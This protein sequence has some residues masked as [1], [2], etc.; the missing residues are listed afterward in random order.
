MKFPALGDNLFGKIANSY[1]E[2]ASCE[3]VV[4]SA[5]QFLRNWNFLHLGKNFLTKIAN[6]DEKNRSLEEV[7]RWNLSEPKFLHPSANISRG[8]RNHRDFL[9]SRSYANI[10]RNEIL[11]N[12]FK[13]AASS[14]TFIS[15]NS[16]FPCRWFVI[17]AIPADRDRTEQRQGE[18]KQ[19]GIQVFHGC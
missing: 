5:L 10:Y 12:R 11:K 16:H 19:R 8:N 7:A 4:G 14:S 2:N 17:G 18:T 3:E 1:R 6:F 9:S 13:L 15:R